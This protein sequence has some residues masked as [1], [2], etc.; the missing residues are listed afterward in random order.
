MQDLS[1]WKEH[2]L[3]DEAEMGRVILEVLSTIVFTTLLVLGMSALTLEA[4]SPFS[5]QDLRL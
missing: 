4:R 3:R 5:L 1:I 2:S